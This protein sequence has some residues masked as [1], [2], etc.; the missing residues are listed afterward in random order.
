MSRYQLQLM[1]GIIR[2]QN[3]SSIRYDSQNGSSNGY[4]N[5]SSNGGNGDYGDN[6]SGGNGNGNGN[7]GSYADGDRDEG[8]GS[9]QN[10]GYDGSNGYV[11]D[12]NMCG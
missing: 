7:D 1:V 3:C 9:G 8:D 5:G 6:Q 10:S 4:S 12:G 2:F 11:A